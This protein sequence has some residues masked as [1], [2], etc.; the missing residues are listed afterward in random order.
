MVADILG[1]ADGTAHNWHKLNG[2]DRASYVASRLKA[3]Q[4]PTK[5]QHLKLSGTK[6]V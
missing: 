5:P 2:G 4:A 3:A 1:L 6:A